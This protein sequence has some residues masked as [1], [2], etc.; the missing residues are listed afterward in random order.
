MGNSTGKPGVMFYFDHIPALEMLTDAQRGQ[1]L[2]GLICYA[3]DGTDPMEELDLVTGAMWVLMKPTVDRDDANYLKKVENARKSVQKREERRKKIHQILAETGNLSPSVRRTLQDIA[4]PEE[5]EEEARE[6]T[7]ENTQIV[8]QAYASV[9]QPHADDGMR[10]Q[11]QQQLQSQQQSQME[12][13]RQKQIQHLQQSHH[14]S[15]L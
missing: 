4:V 14:Y 2:L 1:L 6:A 3:K 12:L 9:T 10:N 15:Q 5:E 8:T 7:E 13:Q 11:L